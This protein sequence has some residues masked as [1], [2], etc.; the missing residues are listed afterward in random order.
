MG[1]ISFLE[2]HCSVGFQLA[3]AELHDR[4]YLVE[5]EE[6]CVT[7]GD[8]LGFGD[9]FSLY[10]FSINLLRREDLIGSGCHRVS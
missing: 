5:A 1:G 10:S 7:R 9:M 6:V 8:S 4:L 2:L 3:Y